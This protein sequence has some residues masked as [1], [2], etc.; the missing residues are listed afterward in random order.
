MK[1]YYLL[2]ILFFLPSLV[3][4]QLYNNEWINFSNGQPQS[5]QQYFRISVWKE[6]IYRI[7]YTDMVA[8]GMDTA[9]WFQPSKFQ[10]FHNGIEQFIEVVDKGQQGIFRTGDYF[11]FYGKATD[12]ELDGRLYDTIAEQPNP[13]YN[14]FNDTAAYFLTYNPSITTGRRMTIENDTAFSSYAPQNFYFKEELKQYTDEYN[15]GWRDGVGVADNSYTTGEGYLSYHESCSK[16]TPFQEIFPIS[17]LNG[18]EADIELV[19]AGANTDDHN[20]I[21]YVNGIPY[22]IGRAHV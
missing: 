11:E 8:S 6:G 13:Y 15:V 10:L 4:A 17:Q 20:I 14:L 9:N 5:N 16:T 22:E 2:Y 3:S 1:K 18:T 19:L 7:N 21:I 12:G